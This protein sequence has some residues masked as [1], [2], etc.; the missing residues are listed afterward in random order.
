MFKF[1]KD[2]ERYFKIQTIVTE[3]YIIPFIKDAF[4]EG[5]KMNVLEIGCAEA[6]VLKAFTKNDHSCVGIELSESRTEHAKHFMKEEIDKGL[7]S[8]INKNIYD[9][10]IKDDLKM[11]FDLVILKDVIEH[12]HEQHIF[13]SKVHEFLK[14]KGKIFFAFPPWQMPFGGHQQMCKSKI[15][16]KLPYYHILPK[17][18][19]KAILK[20]FGETEVKVDNL[21]EIKDTRIS[22]EQFERI[23]KNN[24][25]SIVKKD[26]FLVNPIYKYKFG[27]KPR[28]QIGLINS[29]PYLR[30]Y[31]TTCAYYLIEKEEIS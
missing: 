9:E 17:P 7:I 12:I 1:H 20:G 11:K 14:P 8:F 3:D 27:L 25:F 19:Y 26:F 21:L 29:L 28:K 5:E 15:L 18:I 2:R 23:C 6:G 10:S 22:I 16:S 24:D 31:L 13:I 30:N 4:V